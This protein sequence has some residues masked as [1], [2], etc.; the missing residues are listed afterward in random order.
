MY[1]YDPDDFSEDIIKN[2]RKVY[3]LYEINK[4]ENKYVK[5]STAFHEL[6]I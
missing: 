3:K 6:F 4:H 2:M 1:K 5:L